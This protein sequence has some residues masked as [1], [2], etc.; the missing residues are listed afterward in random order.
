MIKNKILTVI[1]L[2]LLMTGNAFSQYNYRTQ[3]NNAFSYGERLSFEVNLGFLT[4]AE[5]FMTIGPAPVTYNGRECYDVS[6]EANTRSSYEFIFKVRDV[7]KSYID[8][9][10]IFPW[11]FEQHIRETNFSKDFEINFQQD[12]QK[13]FTKLNFAE[14]RNFTVP[15]YV[16]DL[17]SSFY[18]AR[19]L[20][21]GNSK[22][23]DIITINY[24][25]DDKVIPLNVRYEG[26]EEVDVSAGTFNTFIVSPDLSSG[27]TSKTSDVTIWLTDDD[28]RLPVKVKIGIVIGSL[29]AELTQYSGLNGPL[30]SK[31]GD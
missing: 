9:K 5:A 11:R 30:N 22:K 29:V 2:L 27:F 23:G 3:P 19:T 28:R 13:V 26:K 1:L 18:Y 8:T 15:E 4:V 14:E 12:S 10:G 24:F 16:Q 21:F 31:T 25:T 17:I 6:L 7:Y 20:D